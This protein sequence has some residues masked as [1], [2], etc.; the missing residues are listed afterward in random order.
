[1]KAKTIKAVLRKKIDNWLNTIEDE[2][3][4]ELARQNTIV[5]GGCIASMLLQ[6]K[7]NDYDIYFIDKATAKVVAEYYVE[8]FKENPLPRFKDDNKSIPIFVEDK[9]DR[10]KIVVKSAGIAGETESEDYQYFEGLDDT[11]NYQVDEYIET[12]MDNP[13]S[14]E[15]PKYRPVFLSSNAITL[16][17]GIQIVIRFYGKPDEIHK[18]YDFAHC[19]NYWIASENKLE[20]RKEALEALL[21]R[22]LV[23][24]G[25]KYPLCSI[26]RS[27]KFIKRG[28]SINAGQY[29]KMAMQL[30]QLDLSDLE[31]LEEQLIGVDVAYF[32]EV[33]SKLKE[34]DKSKIDHTYLMMIIDRMF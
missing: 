27:R 12:V 24:Q 23:Y 28:W 19:T 15:K 32:Q 30:N 6:E 26:I 20:L 25:S 34:K 33:I 16:S 21:T 11:Q 31:V 3:V 1:M 4:Q 8:K 13:W 14:D 17:H 18:N 2:K 9:D 22:E 5:T 10:I 7:I 29:L